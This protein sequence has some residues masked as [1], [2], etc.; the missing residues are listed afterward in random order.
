M[1]PATGS[2]NLNLVMCVAAFGVVMLVV[3]FAHPVARTSRAVTAANA[4]ISSGAATPVAL[5]PS[6]AGR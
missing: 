1:A 5:H 4:P 2:S 6:H 3:M